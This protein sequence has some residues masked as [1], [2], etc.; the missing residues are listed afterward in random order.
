MSYLQQK[1]REL[2]GL[3]IEAYRYNK[4]LNSIQKGFEIDDK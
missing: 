1:E 3:E 4:A 2:T